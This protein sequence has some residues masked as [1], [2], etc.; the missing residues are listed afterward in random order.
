MRARRF[1][2][3]PILATTLLALSS[4]GQPDSP[5]VDTSQANLTGAPFLAIF[6]AF[7]AEMAPILAQTRVD[8]QMVVNGRTFHF[9]TLHGVRVVEGITGVGLANAHAT[10]RALLAQVAVNGV[11]FS[12]VAGGPYRVGDVAAPSTWTL[13]TGGTFFADPGW[14]SVASGLAAA[15]AACFEQCTTVPVTGQRVCLDHVPGV[16]VGGDGVSQDPAVPVGCV[17]GNGD[18]FGC[19]VGAPEGAGES[20][21]PGGASTPLAGARNP[22]VIDN[23][24]AAVASEAASRGLPFIGFRGMSDGEADP[25]GLPGFPAQFFVYYRLAARNVAATTM[26]FVDRIGTISPPR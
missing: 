9:G 6:S 21:Q 4:C 8:G 5:S 2:S 7:P 12:G 26:A 20:C 14:L 24:T 17:P 23:E 22:R 25:L 3:I 19:E 18:L 15:R 10:A 16:A 1:F 13:S 11:V